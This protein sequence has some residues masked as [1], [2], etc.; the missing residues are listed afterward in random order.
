MESQRL[1]LRKLIEQEVY[2]TKEQERTIP[3]VVEVGWIFDFKRILLRAEAL[4]GIS[5]LFW[6]K[7]QAEYPFQIGGIE[8][9]AIPLVTAFTLKLREKG[10][11][12]NGFFIRKSRKKHGT[13][14]MI[15]GAVTDEKIM[16][17]DDT[18]NTGQSF[19][20]QVEVI[21]GL[22]KKVD[23]VF[24]ILRYRDESYYDY[25]HTKGIKLFSLFEL[26]D[27]KDSIG[28]KNEIDKKK[29]PV[30]APFV[31]S[32]IFRSKNPDYYQVVPKSAPVIDDT[33]VYFGSDNKSFWALNQSDGSVAWEYK[34]LFGSPKRR[35]FSS[36]ILYEKM[37]YFGA[38]DGNVYALDTETGKRKWIFMEADWVRSSP[39]IAPDLGLIFVGLSFGFWE[40]RGGIV[41]I[42][43]ATGIKKWEYKMPKFIFSP[44]AYSKKNAV[45]VC[46]CNDFSVYGFN[47]KTGALLWNF[48][49][50]GK[51]K[52]SFAFEERRGL[53][54]FG[55][56]DSYVYILKTKTGELVHKIKTNEAIRS[57]PLI[58]NDC[59]YIAS[60]DKN[61]YCID[62]G[63]GTVVW[64]F[65]T[66][67]RILA[68]P[69]IVGDKIY[70][71]SNDARLY[72][73]DAQT[74]KNTA[75]FQA[76]ERI[77]NK[78]AYNKITDTL[79]LP[80]FANEIYCLKKKSPGG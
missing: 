74:G 10:R 39:C 71:G 21:E 3:N 41:A 40:K 76:T 26:N 77:T 51:V 25:F 2:R 20:R 12:A 43:A 58:H 13:L 16:L 17:V 68:S 31:P 48:K 36:P 73:L 28:V 35:A 66:R 8:T 45:V 75:F 65:A 57:T 56:F 9:A 53:V 6:E 44:P 29:S 49:T 69:E 38:G 64:K 62:L 72:E 61:L 34:T 33:K 55:S 59:V 24:A 11:R 5:E 22:G 42:D 47:A 70:I 32:W 46:S 23:A 27:F 63:T 1:A 60:M 37:V 78:I 19:I 50:G 52:E 30:P 14:R 4:D 67:G 54:C 7:C 15:E 79:F 80:T 18:L